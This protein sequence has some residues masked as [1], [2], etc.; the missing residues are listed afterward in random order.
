MDAYSAKN[1]C[2][3]IIIINH[4]YYIPFLKYLGQEARNRHLRKKL[5]AIPRLQYSLRKY[6]PIFAKK[7]YSLIFNFFP[8]VCLL[9]AFLSPPLAQLI[10]IRV[11]L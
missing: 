11:F 10:I 8:L 9:K 3:D 5:F 1:N 4:L 7:N 2:S 6:L